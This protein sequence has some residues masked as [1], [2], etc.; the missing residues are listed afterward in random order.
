MIEVKKN[1]LSFS[2]LIILFFF[3]LLR[4]C[5]QEPLE[6]SRME[7]NTDPIS[8]IKNQYVQDKDM[9]IG[10][11]IEWEKAREYK[12]NQQDIILFTVP[13][14]TTDRE[15][16]EE[17]T[18]R[19]D[20][21]KISGHLWKFSSSRPFH[22][23]DYELT[24]HKIMEKMTGSVTY[25]SLDGSFRYQKR[26]INGKFI[27][28]LGKGGSGPMDSPGCKGCHGNIE[29]VIIPSPG[30]GPV[31]PPSNPSVPIPPIIVIPPPSPQQEKC[32]NAAAGSQKATD[33]SKTSKFSAA[34]QDILNG[35]AQN[36]GE[37]GVGF[38]SNTPN[39]PVDA[40]GVQQ[41]GATSGNIDNPFN[42]PTAD[43]HNHPQNTPPSVGD[44]YSMMLYNNQH[45]TFNT[46]YVV[47]S[48]GTVYALIITNADAFA[49]FLSNYP[50]NQIPG[51]APN[52]PTVLNDE[53]NDIAFDSNTN[54]QK[55]YEN[56]LSYMLDKYNAGIALTKMDG[57]GNFKKLNVSQGNSNGSNTYSQTQCN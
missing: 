39:G 38:G 48:N 24:A 55:A 13:I 4:S 33:L 6:D 54:N 29:E 15:I 16:I 17:L 31:I 9:L 41:L 1:Y 36:G 19:I 18:F 42:Y 56:A 37:N 47:L 10:K 52:F 21:H 27:D 43:M 50:M 7:N 44:V 57:N 51:F 3:F 11:T 26:I 28:E 34:K 14:K 25:I 20:N 32:Q 2:I 35:L 8:Y 30:G 49:N 5:S 40:T 23:T 22:P 12:N 45:S 53:Y 46:R